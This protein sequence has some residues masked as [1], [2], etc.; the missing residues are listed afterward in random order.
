MATPKN[1][2]VMFKF[3][4]VGEA[5]PQQ[6]KKNESLARSHVMTEF[7]KAQREMREKKKREQRHQDEHGVTGN[8]PIYTFE[9]DAKSISEYSRSLNALIPAKDQNFPGIVWSLCLNKNIS[10]ISVS[11]DAFLDSDLNVLRTYSGKVT[12][13]LSQLIDH[14]M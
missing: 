9:N 11:R 5:T 8:K 3:I 14:G 2:P 13:H 4:D 10:S 7:R 6:K 1:K 12:P